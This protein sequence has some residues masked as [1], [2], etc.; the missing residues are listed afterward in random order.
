MHFKIYTEGSTD[1]IIHVA[2]NEARLAQSLLREIDAFAN[3]RILILTC[4][5]M[6]DLRNMVATLETE[7]LS[8]VILV[9]DRN[10]RKITMTAYNHIP[11]PQFDRHSL[12]LSA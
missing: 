9:E 12:T 6:S 10:G 1:R 11:M 4:H 3:K 8:K 2:Q 5:K 7:R